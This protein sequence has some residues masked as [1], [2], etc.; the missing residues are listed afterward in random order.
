MNHRR[1]HRGEGHV[2]TEAEVGAMRPQSQGCLE[3]P[4]AGRSK[5]GFSLESAGTAEPCQHLDVGLWASTLSENRYL[6]FQA[7]RLW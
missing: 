7:T 1:R 4:G 5:E 3:P 2:K 6:F